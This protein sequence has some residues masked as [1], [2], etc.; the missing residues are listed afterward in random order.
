MK[1]YDILLAEDNAEDAELS[2]RALKKNNVVN[3]VAWFKDGEEITN[4]LFNKK[5]NHLPKLI[6]LDIKMPKISGIEV[7][8]KIRSTPKTRYLNVVILTS[9]K[10][11][12][13]I[14]ESYQLGVNSYIVKPVAFDKFTAAVSEI[15]LYW[16]ML[17][18]RPHEI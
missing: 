14:V 15:G 8:E 5:L 17:N 16:M 7:L 11:D 2:I 3:E 12:K 6:L 18:E 13:D 4:Y 1:Q 10:E 9:S